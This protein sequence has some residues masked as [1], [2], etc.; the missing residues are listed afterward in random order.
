MSSIN[1]VILIGRLG[2]NP[3]LRT[4]PNGEA[5][6]SRSVATNETW[7]DR[8]SGEKKEQTEWHRCIFF[9]KQA[10]TVAHYLRKGSLIYIE[11]KLKT[12]QW[13]DQDGKKQY[14]TE[15]HTHTFQFLDSKQENPYTVKKEIEKQGNDIPET[16]PFDDEKDYPF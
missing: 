5:V 16:I 3:E 9:R 2:S 1:K 14:S 7:I 11:G 8:I 6:T 15:I 10:E 13:Q 4:M 12:K